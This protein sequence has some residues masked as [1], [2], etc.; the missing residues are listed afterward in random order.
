MR[1]T[2][3]YLGSML[4]AL[5]LIGFLLIDIT[6]F[7]NCFSAQAAAWTETRLIGYNTAHTALYLDRACR[8][9]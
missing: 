5:A 3:L 1:S 4:V 2:L 8:P 7:A 9:R 6:W